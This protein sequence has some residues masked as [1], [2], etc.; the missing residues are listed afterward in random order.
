VLAIDLDEIGDEARSLL[1]YAGLSRAIGLL[2]P[3]LAESEKKHYDDQAGRFG[4]RLAS[5]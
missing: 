3:F 2:R 5:G 1:H 4:A